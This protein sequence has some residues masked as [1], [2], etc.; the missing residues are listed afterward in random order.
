MTHLEMLVT[1]LDDRGGP[2]M[3]RDGAVV[4]RSTGRTLTVTEYT[5]MVE[6]ALSALS[7][8]DE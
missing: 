6:A 3:L 4:E 8:D 5:S 1:L 7:E 2:I